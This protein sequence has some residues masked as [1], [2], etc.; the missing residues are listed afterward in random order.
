MIQCRP[1][2][3]TSV[4]RAWPGCLPFNAGSC[5]RVLTKVTVFYKIRQ[6]YLSDH[7]RGKL[8][9]A[10]LVALFVFEE[11]FGLVYGETVSRDRAQDDVATDAE[12]SDSTADELECNYGS[13][14][15]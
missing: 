4:C 3:K 13:Q 11:G 1:I 9:F 2:G 15:E 5:Y 6:D 10:K 7:L 12:H 8:G 14:E